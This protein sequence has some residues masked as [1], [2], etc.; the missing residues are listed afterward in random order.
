MK[1]KTSGC[2]PGDFIAVPLRRGGWAVALVVRQVMDDL[3][4]PPHAIHTYGFGKVFDRCPT[5][6]DAISL[7]VND[8]VCVDFSSDYQ[9]WAGAWPRLGSLPAFS[10]HD[11]P[12]PPRAGTVEAQ[13]DEPGERLIVHLY[14]DSGGSSVVVGDATGR[15][16]DYD[17]YR[18]L[19]HRT[20]LGDAEGLSTAL[21]MA[22]HEQHPFQHYPLNERR[23]DIWK[24]VV[25][26]I[27][28]HK[29]EL[30]K[31]VG[32]WYTGVEAVAAEE[33]PSR[34]ALAKPKSKVPAKGARARTAAGMAKGSGGKAK[35]PTAGETPL[36]AKPSKPTSAKKTRAPRAKAQ[37]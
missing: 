23:M 2:K 30:A 14:A 8:V 3:N 21:D 37:D 18:Q 7:H 17:E 25:H 10:T 19:P 29:P 28:A 27:I 12:L 6:L 24:R 15:L 31:I 35:K 32:P 4:R 22:I 13:Y 16:I 33:V 5:L 34:A 20:G 11:W 9:V 36:E 1:V 26:R